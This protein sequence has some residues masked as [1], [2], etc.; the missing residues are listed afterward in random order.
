M[1]MWNRLISVIAVVAAIDGACISGAAAQSAPSLDY[2]FFKS[3]VEP[4]FLKKR[5]GH[6]RCYVCHGAGSNNAF[7]L[8][9]LTAGEKSWNDEQSRRNFATVSKL[10][11]AGDPATSRLLMQPLAPEAGGNV[12]HSGGRQF[13]SKQEPDYQILVQWVS[14]AKPAARSKK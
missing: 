2:D 3:R 4:V 14:G 7:K 10:V 5:A 11:T 6:A 13:A 9:K 12:Y 1:T 8:E